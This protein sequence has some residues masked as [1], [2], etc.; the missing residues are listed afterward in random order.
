MKLA[1]K[2]TLTAVIV[3]CLMALSQTAVSQESGNVLINSNPQGA[4]V[5][6]TGELSLSGV[7]PVKFDRPLTGQY[8]LN[9]FR[10][11]YENYRS[12]NYFS[13]TQ[14]SQLNIQLVP[15]TRNKAF[16]RSLIIPGWGQKYYGNNTKSSLFA[17]GT[18][19]S[20]IGYVL[21]KDD[22]DSKADDYHSR[23]E[24]FESA[25]LW[26]DL[27]LLESQMLDAQKKADDAE[28]MVNIMTAVV[29]GV[30]LLN[31]LDSFLFFPDFDR[32]TEYKAITAAP[33]IGADRAGVQLS[34]KF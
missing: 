8:Q 11:G 4:L 29:G 21:V 9:L 27:P 3:Y 5:K 30:Y 19:A 33:E 14:Q 23:K 25:T 31:L 26:S 12:T 10:E 17:V 13:E 34:V 24:A 20:V 15:K 7:T 32:Y 28:K 1:P 18:V 2:R 6:L 16:F 22:Y